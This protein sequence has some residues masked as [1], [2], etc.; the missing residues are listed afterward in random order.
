MGKMDVVN[1]RI[2][3]VAGFLLLSPWIRSLVGKLTV[4]QPEKKCSAFYGTESVIAGFTTV[5]LWCVS[6]AR[7]IQSMPS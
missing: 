7:L 2:V 6:C 3:F 4:A 5:R 1:V